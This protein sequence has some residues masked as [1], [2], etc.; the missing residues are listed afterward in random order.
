MRN[1]FAVA[2]AATL[3][4]HL[5]AAGALAQCAGDC[6][7]E[8][9]DNPKSVE[10]LVKKA[11]GAVAKCAKR[12]QPPCPAACEL[13]D[14][15]AVPYALSASCADLVLCELGGL[16]AEAYGATWDEAGGCALAQA[17]GCG[18]A[19]GKAAGKLVASKLKRRRTS[20]MDKLAK[21]RDKC[22]AKADKAG[23]C[24]GATICGGAG[25]W[26]DDVVPIR[27]AKGGTQILPFDAP[28]D[29][30]GRATLTL[31]AESA[32]WGDM[33]GRVSVV[34]EYDVD[35]TPF[36]TIVVYDGA[37]PAEYRVQLG[38]L[39]A[40]PHEIALRH[41]K[42][43]S[44]ASDSPVTIH[45]QASVDVLAPSDPGYDALRFAPVLLGIDQKLNVLPNHSGNAVSD[46]PVVEYVRSIPGAGQTT[47]RYVMIWS[48]EDGGTGNYPDVMMAQYGRTTD[49]EGI[50]EVD[51]TDAGVLSQVRY[52]PDESGSLSVF[53]GAFFG[54]HPI[55]RTRTANG[56][57][58]DDGD[59]TLK[60]LIAPFEFDD[61]GVPRER[62][63]D[64]DPVSY[65]V[66]GKEM[67][68]E[69]KVEPTGNPSGKKLSD[70]RNY[71][72]VEYDI[73]VDVSGNVLRAFAVVD[74]VAYASDHFLPSGGPLATNVTDGTG[75]TTVELPPGTTLADI[76]SYGMQGVGTMSGTLFHIEGFF[77]D[78]EFLPQAPTVFDG[79]LAASGANPVWWVVP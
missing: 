19:R 1:L 4:L 61:S 64:L 16:A 69:F 76:S 77:L 45:A 27:L 79:A 20:K 43:L 34:V 57:I 3:L 48:N 6:G 62:G 5:T 72:F 7:S 32:D 78:A 71:L 67:I 44:P 68:R 29:G 39:L 15:T 70:A 28:V 2:A 9:L 30:E 13:P 51:V 58:S 50:V 26:I 24:D 37:A 38:D 54:T 10:K 63:M 8:L 73:D 60:F 56:L 66:M 46:V 35:G 41:S 49:I 53:G 21:D 74:G 40:G 36:G 12:G 52:R 47:H 75:R 65:R 14:A 59:S 55:V 22:V 17:D 33:T 42:K 11:W 18:N 23:A 31:A 25:G